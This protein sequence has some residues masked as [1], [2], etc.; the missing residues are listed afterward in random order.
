M[1]GFKVF[2]SDW[3]CRGFQY[4]VGKTYEMN[5]APNVCN[6]GFHFCKKAADCFGYYSFD[7]ANKVAEIIAHGVIAEEG[8]RAMAIGNIKRVYVDG[9]AIGGLFNQYAEQTRPFWKAVQNRKISIIVSDVL[10]NEVER[11]PQ[12]VRDFFVSLPESQ[13]ERVVSTDESDTLAERYIAENVVGPTCLDD[14]KHIALA[15]LAHA[16]VLVSWNFKHLVNKTR[17]DGY[18]G[19]NLKLGY[20]QVD[21]R[22]PIEVI[23]D[24][25]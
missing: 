4:E 10:K 16:S 1:N 6:R 3:T 19:V 20:V 22:T 11:D 14:C 13:I 17:I 24:Y 25:T 21:I 12:C 9:C 23:H 7:P 8:A 18:N 2:N 5:G 15:T